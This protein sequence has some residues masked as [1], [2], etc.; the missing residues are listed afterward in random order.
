MAESISNGR[1]SGTKDPVRKWFWAREEG[2]WGKLVSSSVKR[3]YH[4]SLRRAYGGL[5]QCL[6]QSRRSVGGFAKSCLWTTSTWSPGSWPC[7]L[8]RHWTC[9]LRTESNQKNLIFPRAFSI[10]SIK[11]VLHKRCHLTFILLCLIPSTI[12]SIW[13]KNW[14]R[15]AGE[16]MAL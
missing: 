12:C 5:V 16:A 9:F 1:M 3:V 8:Q 6:A 4:H 2:C 7:P 13:R 15:A 10:T 14:S 11:P